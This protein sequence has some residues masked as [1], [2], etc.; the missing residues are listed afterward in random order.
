M[1][2]TRIRIRGSNWRFKGAPSIGG[3]SGY[4]MKKTL[5][6]ARASNTLP[7]MSSENNTPSTSAIRAHLT[8]NGFPG[9]LRT[10]R[11]EWRQERCRSPGSSP[12]NFKRLF[13]HH[14]V[15]VGETCGVRAF[16]ALDFVSCPGLFSAR[17]LYIT[18]GQV[19]NALL[20]DR[21]VVNRSLSPLNRTGGAHRCAAAVDS[22][23]ESFA[24]VRH[25]TYGRQT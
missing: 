19:A 16:D 11:S 22:H 5:T 2:I 1:G 14:P 24:H 17:A 9:R 12:T 4:W 18:H 6:R 25:G 20:H 13:T 10:P 15:S 7:G 21:M 8:S 3:A 23:I